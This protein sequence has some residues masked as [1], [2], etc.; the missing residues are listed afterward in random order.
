MKEKYPKT[1]KSIINW[2]SKCS[3]EGNVIT[4]EIVQAFLYG[5]PRFLYD[6]FDDMGYGIFPKG[7][8]YKSR[9]QK[10]RHLFDEAFKHQER[11]TM[12]K[13]IPVEYETVRMPRTNEN[14]HNNAREHSANIKAY[15]DELCES[16]AKAI[17]DDNKALR[18]NEGK[19]EWSLVD[20][21]AF[22]PMVKVLMFG[23][24]KYAP[25][26]WKK[27]LELNKIMDSLMRHIVAIQSGEDI[28]PESSLPHIGHIQ[29]NVMFYGHFFQ[30]NGVKP[31]TNPVKEPAY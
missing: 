2:L 14:L 27:G 3:D 4:E 19:L 20:Y 23:A 13:E 18:Y 17:K 22:E 9:K 21:Q 28:D 1:Y 10:K 26:N 30:K 29:C 25:N 5:N 6:Y 24:K 15:V 16:Q 7:G 8:E 12:S 31:V 11:R